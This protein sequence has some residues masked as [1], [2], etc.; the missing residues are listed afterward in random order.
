MMRTLTRAAARFASW[1]TRKGRHRRNAADCAEAPGFREVTGFDGGPSPAQLFRELRNTAYACAA[2]NAA[3]C[4]SYPPRLYVSTFPGQPRPR[5]AT[6]AL[7]AGERDR[8]RAAP[9]LD[10]HT[11]GAAAVEEVTEHPILTLFRSVNEE[12]NAWDLWELTTLYQEVAGSA[13]WLIE[14]GPF[15]PERIWPL[16]S[17]CVRPV[18]APDSPNVV[19][20]YD[21]SRGG[22]PVRYPAADVIHFKYPDPRDPYGPGLA[23]LRACFDH[24]LLD[25]EYVALKRAKFAN[26]A[27]P[28]VIISPDGLVSQAEIE[29]LEAAW[30]NKFLRGGQGRALVAESKMSVT[31]LSQALGDLSALAEIGA[32]RE[33]IANAFGVPAPYL[34]RETNLANLQA[35]QTLHTAM[36]VRPRLI[37]R[38]EKLNERLVPLFDP[39]GRLFLASDD[40]RPADN[41]R[42]LRQQSA[43]VEAGIRTINEVRAELGLGPV[44]WGDLPPF[45]AAVNPRRPPDSAAP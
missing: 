16:P 11:K 18:R 2:L 19:D 43:H 29:R 5:L 28:G 44:P 26:H 39:T 3:V 32:S 4:A 25:A 37:R 10:A 6:K 23:P 30:N 24:V 35:A 36:T 20:Y 38:D 40:P 22:R 9:H 7:T 13:Y 42:L 17:H 14:R 34:F 1:I 8:L 45:L 27:L 15:A 33:A 41:D 12:H 31:V 21:H